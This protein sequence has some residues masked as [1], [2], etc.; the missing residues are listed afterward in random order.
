MYTKNCIKNQIDDLGHIMISGLLIDALLHNYG[1]FHIE[2]GEDENSVPYVEIGIC[3]KSEMQ[4]EI[5]QPNFDKF[6]ESYKITDPDE[7]QLLISWIRDDILPLLTVKV[8]IPTELSS[9]IIHKCTI[10]GKRILFNFCELSD[11]CNVY[12]IIIR[13]SYKPEEWKRKCI[14]MF[15]A[16]YTQE[17]SEDSIDAII[18]WYLDNILNPENIA[19]TI[20]A[21]IDWK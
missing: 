11:H 16:A 21:K 7:D 18:V 19:T 17:E 15:G 8:I 9:T 6:V 14:N 2:N 20:G 12:D 13:V 4:L 3:A 1:V 10:D 5:P